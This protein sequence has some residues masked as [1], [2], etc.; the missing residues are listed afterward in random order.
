MD[1]GFERERMARAWE[2]S[3]QTQHDFADAKGLSVGTLRVASLSV[4]TR[5]LDTISEVGAVFA[6]RGVPAEPIDC[7]GLM[8]GR[9]LVSRAAVSA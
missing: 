1:T 9:Q 8:I 5:G 7:V 6:R 3:G 4:R 2:I